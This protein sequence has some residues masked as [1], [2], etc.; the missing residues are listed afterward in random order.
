MLTAKRNPLQT[1]VKPMSTESAIHGTILG[2]VFGDAMGLP[3]EALSR[4]RAQRLWG[5]PDRHHFIFGRGM[6]SDDGE[7]TCLVASALC[8]SGADVEIFRRCLA[9]QFRWW[10][11]GFPAGIGSATLRSLLKLWLGFSPTRSGVFS[12][13]NGPACQAVE[14]RRRVAS[15][16]VGPAVIFRNLFFALIVLLHIGRRTLPPY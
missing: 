9:W 10:L 4:C 12:A 1:G 3:Y 13:G 6:M 2:T 7:H 14:G 5:E 16:K 15:P 11:L 8:C